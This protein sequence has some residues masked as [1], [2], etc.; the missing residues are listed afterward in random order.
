[1]Y[2][3]QY[4]YVRIN[5]ILNKASEHEQLKDIGQQDAAGLTV[6]EQILI[7]K[8]LTLK[9]LLRDMSSNY[10]THQLTY[11]TLE[12]AQL[13]HAYYGKNKVIDVEHIAQ[14]R[15]RLLMLTQLHATFTITLKLLGLS[16]PEK[17]WM[18][19]CPIASFLAH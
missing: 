11:Y 10:H 7:K 4:A 15:A 5:S 9:E 13:F 2:Y 19:N 6:N 16:Q 1:M 8:I 12:L 3:I 14:S 18:Q 17:M